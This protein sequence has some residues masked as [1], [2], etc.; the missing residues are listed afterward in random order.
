MVKL[1]RN[2]LILI[3][4]LL[5]TIW[6]V[7]LVVIAGA[8]ASANGCE[9]NETMINSCI[10]NGREIGNTLYSMGVM[11][12]FMLVT[13]PTGLLALLIF[14]LLLLIEWI[15]GRARAKRRLAAQSAAQPIVPPPTVP[16]TDSSV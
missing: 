13:I 9:L 2:L 11:G 6:P 8:I 15:A 7:V 16:D 3:P 4:I 12:W 10:V 5:W 1:L 14:L